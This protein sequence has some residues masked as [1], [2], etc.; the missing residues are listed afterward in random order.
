MRI[1]NRARRAMYRV[2]TYAFAGIVRDHIARQ[3]AR[4]GYEV[5]S[6][7]YAKSF[8]E[9]A[10]A[11]P[12]RMRL[13]GGTRKYIHVEALAGTI[14]EAIANRKTK[15]G[16]SIAFTRHFDHIYQLLAHDLAGHVPSELCPEGVAR[17]Y[18][19]HYRGARNSRVDWELW[20]MFAA[21]SLPA[22]DIRAG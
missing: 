21:A 9:F 5:R 8:L 20:G 13:R 7:M 17:L 6:P 12:E 19:R 10:F 2:L 3:S 1:S 4:I 18:D 15:A 16:F 11:I 22:G 14:P